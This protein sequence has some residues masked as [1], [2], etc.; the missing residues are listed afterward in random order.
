MSHKCTYYDEGY[1]LNEYGETCPYND[2]D[3]QCECL[4]YEPKENYTAT[5]TKEAL[6]ELKNRFFDTCSGTWEQ[7][8]KS[9][10]EE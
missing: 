3:E 7:W 9:E 1:C 4:E 6:K 8:L 10:E 2:A 5:F